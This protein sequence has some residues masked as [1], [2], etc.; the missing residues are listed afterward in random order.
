MLSPR[1]PIKSAFLVAILCGLA[2]CAQV[3][4]GPQGVIGDRMA[5]DQGVPG[6]NVYVNEDMAPA[7]VKRTAGP[8]GPLGDQPSS[9]Q[10]AP[11][12]RTNDKHVYTSDMAP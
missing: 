6:G 5:A 8:Q 2:G 4:A 11:G 9:I 10:G 3:P 1:L 7:N 12:S